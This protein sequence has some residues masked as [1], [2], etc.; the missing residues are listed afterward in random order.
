MQVELCE[1][2]SQ[3]VLW[4]MSSNLDSIE[5]FLQNFSHWMGSTKARFNFRSGTSRAKKRNIPEEILRS[6]QKLTNGIRATLTYLT[7]R[8]NCFSFHI[9]PLFN[10]CCFEF[11]EISYSESHGY[12]GPM[13]GMFI[14]ILLLSCFFVIV[15]HG[16]GNLDVSEPTDHVENYWVIE[17]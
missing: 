2:G 8:M 17:R 7:R 1:N 12:L 11:R 4:V 6:H 13:L 3:N 15:F 9:L 16:V 5:I 14:C 10:L